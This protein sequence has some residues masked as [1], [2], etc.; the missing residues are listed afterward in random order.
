MR[1]L[2]VSTHIVAHFM[3]GNLEYIDVEGRKQSLLNLTYLQ[4]THHMSLRP[5]KPLLQRSTIVMLPITHRRKKQNGKGLKACSTPLNPSSY[6]NISPKKTRI[7][8]SSPTPLPPPHARPHVPLLPPPPP[9]LNPLL[10]RPSHHILIPLP[11]ARALT[12]PQATKASEP[13]PLGFDLFRVP[14]DPIPDRVLHRLEEGSLG[15]HGRRG[16]RGRRGGG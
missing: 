12:P 14:L 11:H 15:S 9:R 4:K 6:P 2:D 10:H 5:Q 3:W 7:H 1:L 8:P 13:S 16:G